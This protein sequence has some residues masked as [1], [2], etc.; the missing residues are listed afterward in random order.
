[1]VDFSGIEVAQIRNKHK[2]PRPGRLNSCQQ[3]RSLV[4]YV[5]LLLRLCL[6]LFLASSSHGNGIGD[7][8][9]EEE[10]EDPWEKEDLAQHHKDERLFDSVVANDL[11]LV[12]VSLKVGAHH[13]HHKNGYTPL[14]VSRRV[15]FGACVTTIIRVC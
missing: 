12:K 15:F 10:Q 1:M 7:V 2:L 11:N 13:H 14:M 6:L 4:T 3:N 8:V 9:D 5:M